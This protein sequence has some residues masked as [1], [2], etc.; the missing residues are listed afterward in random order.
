MFL[1]QMLTFYAERADPPSYRSDQT[2]VSLPLIDLYPHVF[3]ASFLAAW[4]LQKISPKREK[5]HPYGWR[6][7]M[8]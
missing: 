3:F 7:S 5:R 2:P 8:F 1:K 4:F 6:F